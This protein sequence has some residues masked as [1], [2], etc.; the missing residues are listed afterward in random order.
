MKISPSL[1]AGFIAFSVALAIAG[2]LTI[3]DSPRTSR[4][5]R[6]DV[7]RLRD[8]QGLSAAI[9]TFKSKTH[10]LP[11]TLDQVTREQSAV[12]INLRDDA[13]QPYEYRVKDDASYELCARFDANDGGGYAYGV[14]GGGKHP[15]G[16]YCFGFTTAR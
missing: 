3:I 8:L 10:G 7:K 16:R 5:K 6:L 9:N 1:F 12:A 2:G 11:E 13:Q 14:P 15:A 4:L